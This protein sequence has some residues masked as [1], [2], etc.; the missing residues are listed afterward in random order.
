MKN[1]YIILVFAFISVPIFGQNVGIGTQNPQSLLHLQDGGM[2]LEANNKYFDFYATSP[3]QTGFRF[4]NNNGFKGAWFYNGE[5][6]KLNLTSNGNIQGLVYRLNDNKMLL[7]RDFVIGSESFGIRSQTT[8]YGGMYLETSGA[9]GRPFYGYATDSLSRMWH[10][11]DGAS[12]SWHLYN[13]GIRMTVMNGGNVGV[14]NTTPLEKLHVQGSIRMD[15]GSPV[16]QFYHQGGAKAE[17][18]HTS[19]SFYINNK[20]NGTMHLQTNNSTKMSIQ[21]DGDIGIGTISPISKLHVYGDQWNL[22]AGEGILSLGSA[23]NR[24]SMGVAIAG[25]GAGTARIYAK[26]NSNTLI[27]GGGTKDVLTVEGDSENVGIGI[28]DPNY[29]LDILSDDLRGINLIN[30]YSGN[31]VKYGARFESSSAGN[32]Q[33]YGIYGLAYGNSSQ[34]SGIYGG[35]F[36]GSGNGSSATVFGIYAQASASGTGNHYAMYTTASTSNPGPNTRSWALYSVGNSYFSNEVRIG[37]INGATGY[38]LSVDGKIMSEEL[39][40]QMSNEWPDYVFEKDYKLKS[41]DEIE[42][43]ITENGHLPGV[44]SANDVEEEGGIH[45]GEMNRILLEKVEE[46]TLLL[47]EQNKRIQ[48]LEHKVNK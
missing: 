8:S 32:G 11:Y 48:H 16:F 38:R 25:I 1:V 47:I 34:T 9:T 4:Y 27:L 3:N 19:N 45:V 40:V 17:L 42:M 37:N 7:G 31:S 24:L 35:R 5:L 14:G 33:K 6:Q 2:R 15:G 13:S 12:G 36:L 41:T 18:R 21:N 44:P 39:K 20:M 22:G 10:Y 23:T 43:F 29:T 30:Q 28:T 26:G 46:L